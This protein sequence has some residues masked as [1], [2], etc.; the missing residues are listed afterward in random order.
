MST[1]PEQMK[2]YLGEAPRNMGSG[3]LWLKATKEEYDK[4]NSILYDKTL[5]LED[6]YRAFINHRDAISARLKGGRKH[7]KSTRRKTRNGR[8]TRSSR[9]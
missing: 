6:K 3:K 9:K 7:K 5:S 2:K 1:S 4:A 8:K